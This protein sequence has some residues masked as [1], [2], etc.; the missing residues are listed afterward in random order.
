MEYLNESERA[1]AGINVRAALA[2]NGVFIT[3]NRFE[4]DLGERPQDPKKDTSAAKPIFERSGDSF[5]AK[6]CRKEHG[7]EVE[8]GSR[9]VDVQSGPA[10]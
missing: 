8:A 5:R 2:E 1:L 10:G 9:E 4:S 6:R 7:G 3:D